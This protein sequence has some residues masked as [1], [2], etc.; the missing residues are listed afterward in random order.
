MNLPS[1]L[2]FEQLLACA[3]GET[4]GQREVAGAADADVRPHHRDQRSRWRARQGHDPRRARHPSGPV[5]FQMPFP[6]RP[7][8]AGLSGPG[9]DVAAHRFLP[10]VAG[11]PG[12]VA[13]W[14]WARSSSPAR[15]CPSAKKVTYEID[16]RRVIS[17]KLGMADR[18]W[19]H[20][21]GRARDLRRRRTLRVGLFT[22]TEGL[23]KH[24]SRR[25][26]RHG[27]RFL[28]GQ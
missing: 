5:V 17:R 13:R 10:H 23:L 24:A 15:Y 25:H 11:C 12:A 4:F 14:A 7:G 8:H 28:P 1:S 20:A 22:S 16:V 3:R 6:G 27:H 18:R 9:C 19:P 26:H 21:G 2:S